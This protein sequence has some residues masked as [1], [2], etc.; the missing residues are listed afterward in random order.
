MTGTFSALHEGPTSAAIVRDV[1]ALHFP[2]VASVLHLTYGRGSFWRWDWRPRGLVLWG[3]DLHVAPPEADS[4][5]MP[6]RWDF[7]RVALDRA[8]WHLFDLVIFDPPFSAMGPASKHGNA[9]SERYGAA[10]AMNGAPQNIVDVERMLGLGIVTATSLARHGVVVKT[11]AVIESGLYHNSPH[12]ATLV[13]ERSGFEIVDEVFFCP[14]RRPQ[15]PERS[16]KHFRNRPSIFI[17]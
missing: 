1:T 14:A 12:L 7:E 16:V 13:L 15:P 9:H 10:R 5:F 4:Q 17:V 6:L 3:S 2:D 11:Q 8:E